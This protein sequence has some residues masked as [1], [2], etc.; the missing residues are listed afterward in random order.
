LTNPQYVQYYYYYY[1]YYT[2]T[3]VTC[4]S[5]VNS[6]VIIMH[7]LAASRTIQLQTCKIITYDVYAMHKFS[8]SLRHQRNTSK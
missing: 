3:T 1:Y 7:R 2:I 6:T 5:P 4:L 8:S